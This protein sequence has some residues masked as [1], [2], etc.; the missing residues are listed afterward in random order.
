MRT[1]PLSLSIL[2][3]LALAARADLW[4]ATIAITSGDEV[5]LRLA[6]L[7]DE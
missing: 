3:F 7:E 6:V 5:F 4:E 2:P 1:L